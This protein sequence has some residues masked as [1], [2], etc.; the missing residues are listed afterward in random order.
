MKK[1]KLLLLLFVLSFLLTGCSVKYQMQIDRENTIK[2][3]LQIDETNDMLD[4]YPTGSSGLFND[5]YNQYTTSILRDNLEKNITRLED[6]TNLVTNNIERINVTSFSYQD[7]I[8]SKIYKNVSIT[9]DNKGIYSLAFSNYV[10][11]KD[12]LAISNNPYGIEGATSFEIVLPFKVVSH[13]AD[14]VDKKLNLY[15]WD[16]D[17]DSEKNKDILLSYNSKVI[18]L[19]TKLEQMLPFIILLLSIAILVIIGYIKY[20]GTVKKNNEI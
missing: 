17:L 10:A 5:M 14:Y 3:Y 18:V 7:N 15:R 12:V 16:I 9:N 4:T 2:E 8:V 1:K 13:N 6:T 11:Y 19:K 20:I